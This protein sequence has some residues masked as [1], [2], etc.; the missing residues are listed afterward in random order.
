MAEKKLDELGALWVRV[1]QAGKR[2]MTG[3]ICGQDV[4]AFENDRK[5]GKAPDWRI[6]KSEP[7]EPQA[8]APPR[9]SRVDDIDADDI[10]F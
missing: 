2:Y 7:R 1:S 4:V 10:G 5:H 3:K 8:A 6:Y 9:P